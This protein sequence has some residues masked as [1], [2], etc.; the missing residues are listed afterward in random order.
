MQWCVSY[1]MPRMSKML[2]IICLHG[3]LTHFFQIFIIPWMTRMFRIHNQSSATFE[4]WK[5][6]LGILSKKLFSLS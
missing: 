2:L 5:A 6:F 4:L 3:D 1:G